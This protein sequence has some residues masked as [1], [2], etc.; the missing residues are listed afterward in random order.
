MSHAVYQPS[1]SPYCTASRIEV[2]SEDSESGYQ[3]VPGESFTADRN[4]FDLAVH[5][6][7]VSTLL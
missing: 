6:A 7:T 3:D 5:A 1:G 2:D 4:F